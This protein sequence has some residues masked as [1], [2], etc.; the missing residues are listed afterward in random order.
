MITL[1]L[2]ADDM[3]HLGMSPHEL[4]QPLNIHRRYGN[5]F[6]LKVNRDKTKIMVYRIRGHTPDI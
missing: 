5:T 6:R 4:E 3:V 1:L 2:F